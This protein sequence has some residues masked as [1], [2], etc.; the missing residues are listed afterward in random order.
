VTLPWKITTCHWFYHHF[1]WVSTR[2]IC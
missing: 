1:W 2:N